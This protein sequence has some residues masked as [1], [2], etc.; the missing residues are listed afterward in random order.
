[1]YFL[2]IES[3]RC[4][5]FHFSLESCEI[6]ASAVHALLSDYKVSFSLSSPMTS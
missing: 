4:V 6:L 5:V 1:M 3:A 2:K